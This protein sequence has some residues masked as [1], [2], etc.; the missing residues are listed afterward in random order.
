MSEDEKLKKDVYNKISDRLIDLL[1]QKDRWIERNLEIIAQ[2]V[3]INREI[4]E[5]IKAANF[6]D[7]KLDPIICNHV[8]LLPHHLESDGPSNTLKSIAL[9]FLSENKESGA[10]TNEITDMY[11]GLTGR[12]IHKK[13]AG[14]TLYR[15]L[16]EKKVKRIGH[17]WFINDLNEDTKR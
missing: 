10:K 3:Y 4:D 13:S 1:Q 16:Q 14:M 15:L 6:F 2:K 9:R 7:I 5:C 12:S 17:V 11:N 8:D